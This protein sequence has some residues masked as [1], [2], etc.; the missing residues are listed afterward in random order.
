[1]A[2]SSVEPGTGKIVAMVQNTNYGSATAEDP[3][4]TTVNLN[5][6]MTRGGGQG[7][8]GRFGEQAVGSDGSEKENSFHRCAS[9]ASWPAS[10]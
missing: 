10:R 2:M 7:F 9:V 8:Q 6:G 4:A 3:N 1:M 5:A